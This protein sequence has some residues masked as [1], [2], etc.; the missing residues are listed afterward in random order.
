MKCSYCNKDKSSIQHSLITGDICDECHYLITGKQINDSYHRQ[1][2]N[3]DLVIW[4]RDEQI[5]EVWCDNGSTS[6]PFDSIDRTGSLLEQIKRLI[7]KREKG[8]LNCSKCSKELKKEYIAHRHF[9]G[10]Y[11]KKCAEEY[12]K[13]N[14][15]KCGICGSPIY[16]CCC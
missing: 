11:C 7:E 1:F 12:K 3:G 2:R 5:R 9:A 10:I 6:I 8:I 15:R 14:S 13:E 16:E 4:I